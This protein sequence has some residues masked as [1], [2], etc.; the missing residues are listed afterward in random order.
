MENI[1]RRRSLGPAPDEL[2]TRSGRPL[3]ATR[4]NLLDLLRSQAEPVTLA[5]L[6]MRSG[7]HENTLRGHLE[8]LERDRL[9]TRTRSEPRGRGRPAWL[10]SATQAVDTE[11]AGLASTLARTL[12]R[13]SSDPTR[14]ARAA[15]EDW[16]R[17][18]AREQAP[19]PDR[20]ARDRVVDLLAATGFGPEDDGTRIRL[21]RCPLLEAA[22]EHP[23]I[24]CSVH[25]G[26]I[27]GALA[28]YGAAGTRAELVPFAEPGACLLHLHEAAAEDG[29][30]G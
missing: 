18:L 4:R 13:T 27:D 25:T 12:R 30:A 20:Q 2:R 29:Q 19:T 5:A 17:D 9:V 23:E 21:T 16:G 8:A 15:G 3:S 1:P 24:V 14:D 11:Y 26:L 7:L 6:V 22:K 28:E 10:W